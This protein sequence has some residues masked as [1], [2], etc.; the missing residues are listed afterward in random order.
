MC[1][2]PLNH[3]F[4]T[5]KVDRVYLDNIY[6]LHGLPKA[7]ISDR[8]PVF[9]SKFWH[10]LFRVIG[11]ELN[12]STPYHPQI[13][14]QSEHVNQYLEIFLRCF[15][16]ARPNHWTQFLSLVEFWYNSSY[17]SALD[18]S[19]FQ[20]LYGHEPRHSGF[21]AA[22]A[23]K[24]PALKEWLEERQVM[25]LILKQHL[26]R[27]RH[28]MKVQADKKRTDRSFQPGNPVYIKLQPYVQTSV[29]RRANHKLAFRY[30][31][32]YTIKRAINPVAYEVDLPPNSKIHPV[33]HV[34]QMKQAVAPGTVIS[35][36]LPIPADGALVPVEILNNRWRH[37]SS[38][39][40]EHL[41]VRWSD[42]DVLDATWEDALSL[43]HRFP[44]LPAWGQY[45]SQGKGDVSSL[46][47]A[48]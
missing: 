24:V 15:I 23:C 3:P 21:K 18:M 16:H 4:T 1:T 48:S 38:G 33:F 12:M 8:D 20:A 9:T 25:Q 30:F 13:D 34:S 39:R 5:A 44:Q 19:P 10:E 40:K 42:P 28:I 14:G 43:R 45:A 27:A 7:I 46:P 6:K 11:S 26:H 2:S 37:T 35:S 36:E 29:A 17:H 22:S 32:L 47:A 41:L 31:G